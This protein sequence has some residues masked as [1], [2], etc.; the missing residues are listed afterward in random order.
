MFFVSFLVRAADRPKV[1][2]SDVC[3]L[4]E[5]LLHRCREGNT[6]RNATRAGLIEPVFAVVIQYNSFD[7]YAPL[8]CFVATAV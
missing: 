4:A 7:N 8:W 2:T 5:D 1:A 6:D 3:G